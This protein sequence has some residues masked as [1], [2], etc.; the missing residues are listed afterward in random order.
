VDQGIPERDRYPSA[1]AGCTRNWFAGG[2]SRRADRQLEAGA[3][4][5]GLIRRFNFSVKRAL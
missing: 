1:A 3:R 4:A 5:S 2:D